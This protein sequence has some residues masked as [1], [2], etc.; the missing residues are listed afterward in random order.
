MSG[1][2]TQREISGVMPE[3]FLTYATDVIQERA[4]PRL[5]DG[6]K[7]VQRRI[8]YA[9][10][11]NGNVSS[12][13]F[14]KAGQTVGIVMGRLHPHGDLSV[15]DAMVFMAQDFSLRYPLISWHG[16]VGNQQGDPAAAYRYTEARLSP[17]GELM[18]EDIDKDTVDMVDNYDNTMKEPIVLG[19]YFPNAIVNP[20]MGIAVGIATT[21]APHYLKDV[22]D[23]SCVMINNMI[24]DKDTDIE[25]LI[26]VIKAPDF[27]TG[28]TI[29]NGKDMPDIYR[30][31]KGRIIL[32]AKYR[33]EQERNTKRIV[34]YE[35]P[36]KINYMSMME[37]LSKLA[38]TISDIRD[39]RD[40]SSKDI[41]IVVELKRDADPGWILRQIFKKTDLQSNYNCNCV[42]I[43]VDGKPK[44][45]I[46]LKYMIETYITRAAKTLYRSMGFER[47]QHEARIFRIDAL[48][49][50]SEHIEE[51]TKIFK[52]SNE[53]VKKMVQELKIS[54]GTAK[55]IYDMKLSNISKLSNASLKNEKEELTK[56]INELSE[57]FLDQKKFLK[58]LKKK[59]SDIPKLKIFKDD[60]R[61]TDIDDIN[62]NVDDRS[63]VKDQQVVITYTNHDIIKS[64]LS[65]D[66]T[67]TKGTS[68]GVSTK[69]RDDEIILDMLTMSTKDDLFCFTNT[70]RV[71]YLPVYK[72]PIVG[73][74]SNGKYLSTLLNLDT[75]EHVI[76]I[77]SA[78]PD[79]LTNKSLVFVTKHGV[80]KRLN[81]DNLST[82]GNVSKCITFKDDDTI[83]S[84]LL[85][86]PHTNIILISNNSK[87]L[88][89]DIDDEKKPIRPTGKTSVGVI[90]MSLNS[91]E[92]VVSAVTVDNKKNFLTVSEKGMVK[93]MTFDM[94]PKKG[95]GSKGV[96]LQNVKKAPTLIAAMQSTDDQE[97]VIITKNGKVSKTTVS[98]FTVHGRTSRGNHG[99]KLE[100]NDIVVSADITSAESE[101]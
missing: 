40:E 25:E 98:K 41:K 82:R 87:A 73:R 70:G 88:C 16:N 95:R 74:N 67:T 47:K 94:I 17:I 50:A 100:D 24:H 55:I 6:L 65:S 3:L 15:Y 78:R 45:N 64:V 48:L 32:R 66:Y 4:I 97:L 80:I 89:I 34:F 62:L 26:H 79:D 27:P 21:F 101:E 19:G 63:L 28:G 30:T 12:K 7:P 91:D 61:R 5:E 60:K 39:V 36:Y 51:I 54:E 23:A 69:L 90:G 14:V 35:L 29:I 75:G 46:N 72:I 13:K 53:P 81:I 85:C 92:Y 18:L 84:V 43:D 44:E 96:L 10:F 83:A 9:M 77:I 2:T 52:T 68:K 86:S 49:F 11:K 99:I 56:R 59:L 1:V 57:L 93:K 58:T 33:I 20:A 42:A 31:G 37:S 76:H 71:H 22:I 38:D 8:L